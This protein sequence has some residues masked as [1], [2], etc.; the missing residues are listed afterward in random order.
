MIGGVGGGSWDLDMDWTDRRLC[1]L[2]NGRESSVGKRRGNC[3]Y[4]CIT[5]RCSTVS[6]VMLEALHWHG[7]QCRVSCFAKSRI[8]HISIP[9]SL[10]RYRI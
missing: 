7:R 3:M 2:K 6:A 5:M 8:V 1:T 9:F 10:C 4:V